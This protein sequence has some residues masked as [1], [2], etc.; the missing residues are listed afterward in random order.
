MGIRGP[1]VSKLLRGVAIPV[2]GDAG[3]QQ[4]TFFGQAGFD[5]GDVKATYGTGNFIL[6]NTG[7]KKL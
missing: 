3:D 5:V 4:A 7:K 6:L 1:E 2:C